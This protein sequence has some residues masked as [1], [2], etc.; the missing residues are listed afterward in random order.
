MKRERCTPCISSFST[1]EIGMQLI[2]ST[3][4]HVHAEPYQPRHDTR[5]RSAA[6]KHGAAVEIHSFCNTHP[7]F[8]VGLVLNGEEM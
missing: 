8:A 5:E 1:Q 6:R 3:A 2:K 7:L 4:R